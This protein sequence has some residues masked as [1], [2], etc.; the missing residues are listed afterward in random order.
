MVE[1]LVDVDRRD[2]IAHFDDP[3]VDAELAADC[4]G[5]VMDRAQLQDRAEQPRWALRGAQTPALLAILL[6]RAPT[7]D[8]RQRFR[9]AEREHV[10]A[11]VTPTLEADPRAPGLRKAREQGTAFD[12]GNGEIRPVGLGSELG[13][14]RGVQQGVVGRRDQDWKFRAAV[15][16][17]LGNRLRDRSARSANADPLVIWQHWPKVLRR[18]RQHD[19]VSDLGTGEQGAERA[20]HHRLARGRDQRLVAEHHRLR[21][22]IAPRTRTR[23]Q[24]GRPATH[25]SQ[26][27]IGLPRA[28]CSLAC[29]SRTAWKNRLTMVHHATATKPASGR[30]NSSAATRITMFGLRRA[31][32]RRNLL[33]IGRHTWMCILPKRRMKMPSITRWA[34]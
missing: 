34:T 27:T 28:A 30:P 8:C 1:R 13:D 2:R 10:G 31:V 6:D 15:G 33:S 32:T 23:E 26:E 4:R 18:L 24:E 16:E 7:P 29:A 5:A 11:A 25:D 12:Y 19:D 21:Q 14:H 20:Q 22:R 9:R 3:D 17:L